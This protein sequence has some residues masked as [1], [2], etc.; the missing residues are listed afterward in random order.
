M[1]ATNVRIA[2]PIKSGE[3]SWMK[4]IPGTVTSCW[5]GQRRQKSR[6]RPTICAPRIGIDEKLG[7]V[8]APGEP[9]TVAFDDP[10]DVDRH[11]VN[12]ELARPYQRGEAC[13]PIQKRRPIRRHF[14][15]AQ[16]PD[17]A[18]RQ[19][20]LDEEVLVEHEVLALI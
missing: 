10:D 12:R 8:L 5:F 14:V 15:I 6:M 11:A 2:A 7:Q 17:D 19:N 13:F 16:L 20:H 9:V 18:L 1:V 4:W 3:S